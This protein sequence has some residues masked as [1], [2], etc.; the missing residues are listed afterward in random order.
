MAEYLDL[1]GG[2]LADIGDLVPV[3]LPGQHHPADA[4]V[5]ALLYP[6]QR[7]DGHLGGAMEGQ[8]RDGLP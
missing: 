6:V 2:V 5:S 7:V 3:Q 8:V 4:Q 1:D